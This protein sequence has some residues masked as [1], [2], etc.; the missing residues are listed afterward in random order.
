MKK[1]LK[2]GE[3]S[4]NG[5]TTQNRSDEVTDLRPVLKFLQFDGEIC[6]S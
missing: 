6:V 5:N 2:K 1:E 3:Y 4:S